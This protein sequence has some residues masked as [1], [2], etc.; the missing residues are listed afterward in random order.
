MAVRGLQLDDS[1]AAHFVHLGTFFVLPRKWY[2]SVNSNRHP[3][4][5]VCRISVC[6]FLCSCVPYLSLRGARR[7]V[8][9]SGLASRVDRYRL[10]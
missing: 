9:F 10:D 4:T 1:A 2:Q 5:I 8:I 6:V 7:S 3:R